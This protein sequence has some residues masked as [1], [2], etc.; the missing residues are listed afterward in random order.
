[1]YNK[2]YNYLA[3]NNILFSKQFRFWAGHS[4]DYVIVELVEQV[5]NGFIE[6]FYTLGVFIDTL[7]VFHTVNH[8]IFQKKLHLYRVKGKNLQWFESYLFHRNQYIVSSK[9][10]TSCQTI[11]AEFHKAQ[12]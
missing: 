2:F 11:H 10:S 9:E 5:T 1:M 8:S 4:T 12:Y 3:K 7:K 6:P